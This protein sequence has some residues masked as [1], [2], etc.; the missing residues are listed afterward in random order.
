MFVLRRA[1]GRRVHLSFARQ[2]ATVATSS[3]STTVQPLPP[4]K[5]T[6]KPSAGPTEEGSTVSDTK[7]TRTR[8]YPRKRPFINLEH[9]KQYS[10][11]IGVGVLPAYD[12]ALAYI[13][14]DS[15]LLKAELKQ[16]QLEL[17]HAQNAP[18]V[19][20][21]EVERLQEKVKILEVQSEINLPSVRWK[22]RNG[23][24]DMT[25]PVYRHLVEQR[26]REEGAL[27]LLME[28]I[29]QMHVVP[30]LLPSLQ[31]SLDLRVNFSEPPPASVYLRTHTKRKYQKV[32]PGIFLLP[33]QTRRPPM[34]YTTVFHTDPRLYTLLMVDLDVP[35]P[36]NQSYQT[37][38]HLLQPNISLSATSPSPISLTSAHTPYIP[39]HP[40]KGTPYH[41]YA[42]LLL[43]QSNLTEP[44]DVPSISNADRLGFDF[45]KFSAQYGLDGSNGGGAH[46]WREI[47]NPTVSEIYKDTL[48]M[49]EPVY[50]LPKKHD[51][52][53]EV[54][55]TKKYL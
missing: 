33:E 35:D 45:R 55:A 21:A 51:P 9:P 22:A 12:E 2:N 30:D 28:R 29:Y 26:W 10:R 23:M 6:S 14:R 41:R 7:P 36:E 39:P 53:A 18:E 38:L 37:Y 3:S 46:M 49:D 32:E 27:D 13:K 48:K 47:W 15:G 19:N 20:Q 1:G 4:A 24:A 16:C 43:P 31:P 44:I 34:L 17:D 40:Q 11:P 42:I 5:P 52:Y 8:D 50:G 54:K 25:K